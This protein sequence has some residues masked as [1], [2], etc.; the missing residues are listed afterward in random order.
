MNVRSGSQDVHEAPSLQTQQNMQSAN[1]AIRETLDELEEMRHLAENWDSYGGTPPTDE[2]IASAGALLDRVRTHLGAGAGE[3]LGP[4]YI[5]PR[6]DGGIQ[7]EWGRP[8]AKV[9]VQV[10]CQGDFSYLVVLWKNGTREPHEKHDVLLDEIVKEIARVV[11]A[12]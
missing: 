12:D 4:E 11:S 10:T 9:S 3:R 6:A 2:A 1:T 7:I 8:P 5:A